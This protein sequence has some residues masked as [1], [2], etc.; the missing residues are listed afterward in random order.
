[1]TGAAAPP[2]LE[3]RF[4]PDAA[5]TTRV[6]RRRV[7]YPYAFLQPF[8]FGDRP[9]GIATAILQSGSGGL[10]GSE[11]LGQVLALEPGAAAHVTSQAATIV[12]DAR[13]GAAAEQEVRLELGAGSFLEY[14]PEPLLLFPGAALAQRIHAVLAPSAVLLLGDGAAAHDPEAGAG[15]PGR[16]FAVWRS[17]LE[18]RL[19]DGRLLFADRASPGGAAWR[20]ALAGGGRQRRACGWFALVAPAAGPRQAGLAAALAAAL[21]PVAAAG[22]DAALAALPNGAGLWCRIAAPDGAGLR[23]GLRAC[24]TAA[25][26]A[27]T[28]APPPRPRK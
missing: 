16:P 20:R 23:A 10:F 24:W 6:V 8:W 19:E 18:V 27:W 15:D 5:G 7:R 21:E 17:S 28:G 12:H 2:Q 4:A 22:V 9:E 13:G 25:R 11:R 3:L 26:T 1:M 14:L